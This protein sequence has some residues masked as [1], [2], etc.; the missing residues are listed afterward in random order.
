MDRGRAMVFLLP[1]R[2]QLLIVL[3]HLNDLLERTQIDEMRAA[4]RSLKQLKRTGGWRAYLQDC[5]RVKRKATDLGQRLPLSQFP[6]HPLC[7][8]LCPRLLGSLSHALL[9]P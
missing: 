5:K 7:V 3:T 1:F 2:N 6:A 8:I 4:W 9:R